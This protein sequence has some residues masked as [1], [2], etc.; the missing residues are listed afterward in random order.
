MEKTHKTAG[1]LTVTILITFLIVIGFNTSKVFAKNN[2]KK[3]KSKTYENILKRGYVKV[4]VAEVDYPG[5]FEQQ[6]QNSVGLEA[7]LARALAA[8]IFAD[9][10]KIEFVRVPIGERFTSLQEEHYDVLLG[11]STFTLSRDTSLNVNFCP[12]YFYGGQRILTLEETD[13]EDITSIAVLQSTTFQYNLEIFKD[14]K[15][16]EFEIVPYLGR[17][18]MFS[19]YESGFVEAVTDAW[20]VLTYNQELFENPED[21]VIL[22]DILSKDP[23]SPVVRHGDDEWYDIVKWVIYALFEAEE[24]GINS[25]NVD[26]LKQSSLDSAIRRFL[27]VEGTLGDDLGL[28]NDWA[29]QIIKLVGNY[30]DIYD[31]NLS[32][33]QSRGQNSLHTEGGLLYSPLM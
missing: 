12:I 14:R 2:F 9:I 21:H 31:K 29:Y 18:E 26:A 24:L 7:D 32:P 4:G 11:I 3:D 5:F 15:G 30:G 25:G 23:L 6:G 22:D 1:L 28:P 10:N 20:E 27:G 8:V 13:L 19:D 33:Y 16:L 17:S